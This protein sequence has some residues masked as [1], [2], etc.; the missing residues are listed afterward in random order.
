MLLFKHHVWPDVQKFSDLEGFL[1]VSLCW[2]MCLVVVGSWDSTFVPA[3][4]E[5]FLAIWHRALEITIWSSW[6]AKAWRAYA[7]E[8]CI[9]TKQSSVSFFKWS[10]WLYVFI[11]IAE[12]QLKWSSSCV[13]NVSPTFTFSSLS[14]PLSLCLCLK[15]CR[16]ILSLRA[17]WSCPTCGQYTEILTFGRNPMNF[18]HQDFWTKMAS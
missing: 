14:H 12:H 6:F 17:A 11:N 7:T 2:M 15:F 8:L 1:G 10:C 9:Y 4:A 16:D 5:L 3:T 13:F 18:N